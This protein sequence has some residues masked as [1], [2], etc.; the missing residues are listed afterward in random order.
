MKFKRLSTIYALAIVTALAFSGCSHI[1]AVKDP[2]P[3]LKKLGR[4]S[5][6]LLRKN[7]DIV[8]V[9]LPKGAFELANLDL[10]IPPERDVMVDVEFGDARVD[11]V[12]YA[13]AKESNLGAIYYVDTNF[14]T[15]STGTGSSTTTTTPKRVTISFKGRV[16]DFLR[17]ISTATGTFLHYENN[18]IV[19]RETSQFSVAIPTYAEVMK[20][21]T[22]NI[23]GLGASNVSFDRVTSSLSFSSDANGYRRIKSFLERLKDNASLITMQVVVM[24]VK[25]SNGY[26]RGIDWSKM[27]WYYKSMNSPITASSGGDVF[28]TGAS[29]IMNGTGA[30]L[31]YQSAEFSMQ[32]LLNFMESQ[33]R[34]EIM[35]NFFAQTM[36]GGTGK[37]DVLTETPYVSEVSL[38]ALGINSSTTTQ[39]AKTATAKQGVQLVVMPY[40][41]KKEGTL[42]LQLQISVLGVTR[43]LTLDAGSQLGKFTQPETTKKSIE[44]F[45]RMTPAQTAIIGGLVYERTSNETSGLPGDTYLTKNTNKET[46]KEELV[47]VIKPTIIEFIESE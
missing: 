27:A 7:P 24:N 25:L 12:V 3:G 19:A 26:S 16:S 40:Y 43:F 28:T 33:G 37:L 31:L 11:Q 32:A 45:V 13:V 9:R 21:V 47:V 18:T 23:Q 39:S 15:G 2:L 34:F 35:Q 29:V 44:S 17:A 20:E 4:Q 38:S 36:S 30:S 46:E 14:T 6:D 8:Q 42:S 1:S 22:I 41:A 10:V 5:D